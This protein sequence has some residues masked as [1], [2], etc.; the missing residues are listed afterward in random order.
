[1]QKLNYTLLNLAV[2]GLSV[3]N[4]VSSHLTSHL[5]RLNLGRI[6]EV[7]SY[8]RLEKSPEAPLSAEEDVTTLKTSFSIEES[9]RR[10]RRRKW[11]IFDIQYVAL[12]SLT[13]V[14]LWMI[15]PAAPILKT[16]AFLG[17]MLLLFMPV[18]SHFVPYDIRPL[19]SV[20]VLPALEDILYGADLSNILS[21]YTHP[22]LD[23][24]AWF[25]YGIGHFGLPAITSALLFLF[26]APGT[27]PRFARSFGWMSIAGVALQLLF[28]CTPPWYEKVHGLAEPAAYG[29][30]GSPAGLARIDALLGL[31]LYTTSF[32]TAP[33]P[34]GAFPSLHAADAA[35]EAMFLGHC[36]PRLRGFCAFYVAWLCWATM[37]LNHHYAVDL[38]GGIAIAAA[39]F[40]T[41]RARWLPLQ[42]PDKAHRW[43]YAAGAGEGGMGPLRKGVDE[44]MGL[45]RRDS[46]LDSDHSASSASTLCG[47]PLTPTGE[48]QWTRDSASSKR[49]S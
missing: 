7:F 11:S 21:E 14:C 27:A 37:Y 2:L 4:F 35:L 6:P 13:V 9:L 38:V 3:S 41:V 23:V 45:R 12:A 42:L 32:T 34:F 43:E 33:V 40:W 15:E 29:M 8:R 18:T 17:Y 20:K 19:V 28:P 24:L 44:E 16:A 47:S 39:I 1:M 31:D 5:S 25:P 48:N 10:L 36:F 46:D 30:A 22:V 26:A 49:S